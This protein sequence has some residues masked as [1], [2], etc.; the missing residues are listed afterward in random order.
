MPEFTL[1]T[2]A[3][4]LVN[5]LV[6]G[7]IY[8]L[9]AI[10]LALIFGVANLINFAHGS[11]YMIGAYM[12]W[13]CV[14]WLG[15]PLGPTF[16]VVAVACAALGV[17][18]ER[19]GLRRLQ[20][21][22][23]IAPL[24]ATIGISF[25]LDQLVQLIFSPNPQSFPSPLPATRVMLGGVSIGALDVLI[26]AITVTSA[27]ML[28]AFLR[29]T[30]LGWALR[31]TAQDREA[32][33]Q[34][35]VD[36]NAIQALTFA[37]AAVLGGIGGVMIGMYFTSVYPTMS[38]GAMLKG[39]AANLL[40]GLGSVPG[41]V[42]GGLLLGLIETF[43]VALLGSTYR[44][45]FTFVILI[46]VLVLRPTG[47]FGARRAMPPEPLTGTF[48]ANSRPV[49]VP[50]FVAIGG[51]AAAVLLPFISSNPYLL[52][53]F[54]NAWLFAMLALSITLVT[55]TAGQMSLG[56]A[57][58]L[59]IGGYAS[60]LLAM[61]LGWPL[62]L[63]LLAGAAI[64][65][66]LGTLLTWPVFR[67]RS[68]YVA[69]ATLGI[70]EVINQVILNWEG[71]TNGVLGLS[72]IPPL[73]LFGLPIIETA[74]IYWFALAMLVVAA[75]F[76]WRLM[77]SHL[78]RTWRAMR[79]DEVAARAF[80]VSLNRYK[81]L[82]FIAGGFIAGLSGAFTAHMYSY[83]NN[84]TFAATTSILGLT[85]VILGGM[86]NMSGAVVGAIALTALPELFRPLADA[87]YLIYGIVLLLLVRFR[88]QGLLG[89]V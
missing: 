24:L 8:A 62:E 29:F 44:N 72:N 50:R 75:L 26:A 64:A 84:E 25:A 34:M 2:L 16:I 20:S 88:P 65:A 86:G 35:G 11:V 82:A 7:N 70:G 3:D 12:G 55:G 71:L 47:L 48:V 67:L 14:T 43:G 77:Q 59:A 19:F 58:F 22:A 78:G 53:I 5:G 4:Q 56:Q 30:R 54:T 61:R 9:I 42:I 76:Q 15:W 18:I 21:E 79:E 36:V 81:A 60:A 39:F 6:I 74:P 63:S 66:A 52:Q 17:L 69:L 33:Q 51:L 1:R 41:A 40:G 32:A 57:G 83:I 38:Y 73:S 80:G 89:T 28:F 10:G 31:A 23:R 46:G 27:A 37:V 87:R 85:M 68:Q 45:L 49:R 13:V